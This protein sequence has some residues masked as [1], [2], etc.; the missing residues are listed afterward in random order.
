MPDI[1]KVKAALICQKT[2]V[3]KLANCDN[4]AYQR[5]RDCLTDVTDDV[6]ELLDELEKRR[7]EGSGVDEMIEITEN[8]PGLKRIIETRNDI[9]AETDDGKIIVLMKARPL[10]V[11]K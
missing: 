4:C 10:Y 1:E 3:G 9:R 5:S 8:I 6:I 2:I 11:L 7:N